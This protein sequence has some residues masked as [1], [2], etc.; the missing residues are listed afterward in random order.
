MTEY[1]GTPIPPHTSNNWAGFM[2]TT[3]SVTTS[4]PSLSTTTS[5]RGVATLMTI[6]FKDKNQL[7][8]VL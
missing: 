6:R 5:L 1:M 4:S 8:K 3:Q 2:N 7:Q